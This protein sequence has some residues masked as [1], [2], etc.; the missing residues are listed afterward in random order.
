MPEVTH[1]YTTS[2]KRC[3]LHSQWTGPRSTCRWPTSRP[4]KSRTSWRTWCGVLPLPCAH[5][6]PEAAWSVPFDPADCQTMAGG[7]LVTHWG[8]GQCLTEL[9]NHSCVRLHA[10]HF[11]ACARC[12]QCLCG[13]K[14]RVL[15]ERGYPLQGSHQV[16]Y[17]EGVTVLGGGSP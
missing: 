2:G 17:Q 9:S 13:R 10:H 6:M 15:I 12:L 5:S 7:G 14:W 1:L 11:T 16:C 8:V 3:A 4:P